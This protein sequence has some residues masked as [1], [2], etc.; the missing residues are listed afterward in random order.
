M[1]NQRAHQRP[2]LLIDLD[3]L[4]ILHR[5]VEEKK[6]VNRLNQLTIQII[7]LLMVFTLFLDISRLF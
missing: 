6:R 7:L 5:L 3:F 1:I 2:D 4:A